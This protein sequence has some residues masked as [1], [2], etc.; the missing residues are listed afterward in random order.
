M[1]KSIVYSLLFMIAFIATGADSQSL[2]NRLND[3]NSITNFSGTTVIVGFNMYDNKGICGQLVKEENNIITVTFTDD[4]TT[5]KIDNKGNVLEG[6]SYIN[7]K[8]GGLPIAFIQ[9]YESKKKIVNP[10][11]D[12]NKTLGPFILVET[13]DGNLI[14]GYSDYYKEEKKIVVRSK[15]LN[16]VSV[17]KSEGSKWLVTGSDDARIKTGNS[18]AAV[19]LYNSNTRRF[20]TKN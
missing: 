3:F 19:Y 20:Y 4:N 12:I 7:Q 13:I 15:P 9:I 11:L 18:I 14:F 8:G 6:E 5:C 17:L 1:K 16:R 2:T 10:D